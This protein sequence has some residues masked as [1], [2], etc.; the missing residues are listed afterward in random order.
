MIID[1]IGNGRHIDAV[2]AVWDK[3]PTDSDGDIV[4]SSREYNDNDYNNR[5]DLQ[6]MVSYGAMKCKV[7]DL[8][9]VPETPIVPPVTT[10]VVSTGVVL[11]P[12]K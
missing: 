8:T 1:Y 12:A 9:P 3:A 2:K 6:F 5:P 7:I 11:T 10:P 4:K